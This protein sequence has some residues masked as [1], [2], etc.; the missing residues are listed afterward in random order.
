MLCAVMH[1]APPSGG[2]KHRKA[3][4]ARKSHSGLWLVG[5]MSQDAADEL[6]RRVLAT[7]PRQPTEILGLQHGA[8]L[9]EAR[10][11]YR[12]LARDLHPDKNASPLALEA[13]RLCGW[14]L[15]R[16]ACRHAC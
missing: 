5:S 1:P 16:N 12:M 10:R 8:S 3:A 6:A 2:C 15:A 9:D 7:N 14:A 13:F 11:A 4:V